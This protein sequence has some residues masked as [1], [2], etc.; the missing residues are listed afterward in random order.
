MI[1]AS[2]L[3]S[4][5]ASEDASLLTGFQCAGMEKVSYCASYTV[6]VIYNRMC[7]KVVYTSSDKKSIRLTYTH[8]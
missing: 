4:I 1:N 6:F 3:H 5:N 8:L 7:I 2:L